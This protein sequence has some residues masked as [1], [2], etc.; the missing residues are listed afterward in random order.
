MWLD[1]GDDGGD[2]E[3][4]E[5][6]NVDEVDEF[7]SLMYARPS[8]ECCLARCFIWALTIHLFLRKMKR[9]IETTINSSPPTM[10][11]TIIFVV[12]EKSIIK[13][14]KDTM[15]LVVLL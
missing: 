13:I 11:T 2:A 9:P 1:D 7:K 10:G 12:K 3:P 8:I 6:F 4:E 5:V 15:I 14:E